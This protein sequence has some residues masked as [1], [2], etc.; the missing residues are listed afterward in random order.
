MTS[1]T[2]A[3][4]GPGLWAA[5]RRRCRTRIEALLPASAGGRAELHVAA[6]TRA[7]THRARGQRRSC[8]ALAVSPVVA[9]V[10]PVIERG[11]SSTDLMNHLLQNRIIFVGRVITDVVRACGT[12]GR[13]WGC[14]LTSVVGVN[15]C[16]QV[17][18]QICSAL[19]AL[20]LDDP[21]KD[22]KARRVTRAACLTCF[23]CADSGSFTC[24]SVQM[25]INAGGGQQYSIMAVIDMM[26]QVKCDIQTVAF[27]NVAS[28][29]VRRLS[30]VEH[31][32]CVGAR[33][34][35]FFHRNPLSRRWSWLMEQKASV[36]R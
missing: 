28:T 9:I 13:C 34:D 6:P 2:I 25:Y 24:P 32:L 7:L 18:Q 19:M 16:F 15:P 8:G 4:C 36:S 17:A 22:I 14:A 26:N 1:H 5:P 33:L 27:G 23:A 30:I 11:D 31:K 21:T 12:R 3:A 20:E 10:A 35:S 29:A